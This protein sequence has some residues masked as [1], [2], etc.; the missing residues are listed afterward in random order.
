M[1]EFKTLEI[2]NNKYIAK[3]HKNEVEVIAELHKGRYKSSI[4]LPDVDYNEIK[5]KLNNLSKIDLEQLGYITSKNS[6][7]QLINS[8]LR[9]DSSF[10]LENQSYV[11]DI[12][13]VK[14]LLESAHDKNK[15]IIV[16][17][18][19]GEIEKHLKSKNIPYDL[20]N[21]ANLKIKYSDLNEKILLDTLNLSNKEQ[22]VIASFINFKQQNKDNK[23]LGIPVLDGSNWIYDLFIVEPSTLAQQFKI[24][25]Y[26]I[27]MLKTSMLKL[28]MNGIMSQEFSNINEIIKRAQ[29]GHIIILD[30]KESEKKLVKATLAHN[31]KE[32]LIVI[33]NTYHKIDNIQYLLYNTTLFSGT[34]REFKS[35]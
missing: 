14:S 24:N 6:S 34:T 19:N 32:S 13:I 17:D 1:F 26:S 31:S 12:D 7:L 15:G 4:R 30:I 16:F 18:N 20:Y 5:D 22:S 11:E 25:E 23:E 33:D 28:T 27:K 21:K 3:I 8:D 9:L 29:D 10:L 35:L 2:N